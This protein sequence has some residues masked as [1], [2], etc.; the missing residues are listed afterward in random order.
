MYLPPFEESVLQ[1]AV[2][3]STV[4]TSGH[5]LAVSDNV[6]HPSDRRV[7]SSPPLR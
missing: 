5:M 3:S 2:A 6:R 4:E 7:R 1:E